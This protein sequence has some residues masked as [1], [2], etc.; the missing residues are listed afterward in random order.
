ML[1]EWLPHTEAGNSFTKTAAVLLPEEETKAQRGQVICPG[2]TVTQWWTWD[3]M[4]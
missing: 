3:V 4:D 2:H 1:T